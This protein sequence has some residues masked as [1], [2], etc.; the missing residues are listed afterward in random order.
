MTAA[1]HIETEADAAQAAVLRGLPSQAQLWHWIER[2][3]SFGPRL[4]GSPAHAAAIDFLAAELQ[5]LG[6]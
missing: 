3:N 2:L 1:G 4:T 6:L 5:A